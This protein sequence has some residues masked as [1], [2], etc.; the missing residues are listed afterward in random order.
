MGRKF[1]ASVRKAIRGIKRVGLFFLK[2]LY[3]TPF[4]LFGSWLISIVYLQ[5]FDITALVSDSGEEDDAIQIIVQEK[6]GV[7]RDHFHMTDTYVT[8]QEPNPPVCVM[9]HGTYPHG[10]KKKVR[11]MLNLH[12]GFISCS[13]CHARRNSAGQD[14]EGSIERDQLGFM[15]VDRETG[16]FRDSVEGEYGKY[17]AKIYPV[18]H[19][20]DGSR[21]I[22]APINQEAAQRFLDLRPQLTSDQVSEAK[23]K[24]HE[25]LS[26]QP[27]FCSDCHQKD[28]YMDYEKLGFEKRRI[29][30]IVS[31]EIVGM[32]DKY[33]T[34]YLPSVIDF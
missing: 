6:R 26:E 28:S 22:H 7:P 9:C 30:H 29:D 23:A 16:E 12:I 19:T 13:V 4:I 2:L 11:S 17:P 3:I 32:I 20:Q 15:W 1:W 10:K 18:W 14:P 34:F 31:S 27:V 24:L 33:K 21:Q 5:G 25:P 8:A